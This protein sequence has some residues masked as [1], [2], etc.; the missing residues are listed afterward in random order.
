MRESNS[1]SR[2]AKPML[3]HLTNPPLAVQGGLEPPTLGLTDRRN[4]RLCYWTT[5]NLERDKGIEPSSSAWKAV[6]IPLY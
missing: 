1:Q 5:E 2:L 3:S 6:I 4:Y